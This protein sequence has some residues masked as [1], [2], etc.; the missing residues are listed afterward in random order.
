MS[1]L[2]IGWKSI[3]SH[4]ILDSGGGILQLWKQRH[5]KISLKSLCSIA[6]FLREMYHSMVNRIVKSLDETHGTNTVHK[7]QHNTR[8]SLVGFSDDETFKNTFE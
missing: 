5:K 2:Y 7:H 1:N 6:E 4:Q 8:L 3:K